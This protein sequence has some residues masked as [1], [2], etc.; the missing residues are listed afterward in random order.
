MWGMSPPTRLFYAG[1]FH[2]TSLH[3][4]TPLPPMRGP[5]APATP[6]KRLFAYPHHYQAL[7]NVTLRRCFVDD[8]IDLRF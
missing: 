2:E 4:N 6:P 1:T 3:K 5:F 8:R 7:M